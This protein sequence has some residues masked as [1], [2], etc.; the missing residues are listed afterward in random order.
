V[1]VDDER[2]LITSANFTDRGQERNIE[3]GV[4]IED[5]VFASE[6]AGHWRQLVNAGLVTRY[7][8]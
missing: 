3:A 7:A 1:V 5:H 6:L 4:L 2:A 8:G